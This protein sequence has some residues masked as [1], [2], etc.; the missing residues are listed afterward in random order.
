MD[1]L[2]AMAILVASAE[3]GSFSAAGRKLG[4]PLP[5][6][7]RKIG[8]LEAHLKTRLFVRS[9]RKLVLTE[10]GVVYFAACR[11]ILESI[12]EA[13]AQAAGEYSVPRGDLTL[14]APIVFGRLH[15]VPVVNEFLAQFAEINVRMTLS[16]RNVNLIDDHID[17]AVRVGELPDSAMIATRVGSIRRVVCGSPAYF[18]A[19]G[20]PRTPHELAKH[21]CVT[22]SAMASTSWT[23]NRRGRKTTSVAP[24]CRLHINTAEAAIDAAIAGLGVTNVLSY[25]VARAVDEKKLRIILQDFEPPPVPIHLVHAHQRLLPLKMRRFLEF[26]APRIRKSVMGT[27]RRLGYGADESG[28]DD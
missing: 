12:G 11:R 22:F 8:D 28:A 17:M 20:T 4:I 14:T 23:F 2:D 13:E 6:V 9:T 25:Q 7:S 16:D 26:A 15:V 1:R 5:T 3:A 24:Q 27:Q 10:A 18:A 21:Q 19:H